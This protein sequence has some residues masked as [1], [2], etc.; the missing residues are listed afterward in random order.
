MLKRKATIIVLALIAALVAP[1][2]IY[3]LTAAAQDAPA[4][5]AAER[6]VVRAGDVEIVVRAGFNR[7]DVNGNTGGWVPFRI[8]VSNQGEPISGRLIVRSESPANPNK[9][10]REFVKDVQLP[11]GSRQLHNISAFLNSGSGPEVKL[12]TNDNQEIAKLTL[13]I[14]RHMW[15]SD[16]LEIAVVDTD[17]TTLNNITSTEIAR[18]PLREPFKFG[19]FA[20][21]S[22]QAN[23]P[24]P[25]GPQGR[26]SRSS[27][28]PQNLT[29][30]PIVV[31]SEDLPRE[32]VSYDPVDVVVIGDAPLSQLTEDQARALRL[33]VASGGMLVVTGA[34]DIAGLRA[35]GLDAMLPVEVQ[36]ATT[37]SSLGA[38]SA[39]YGGFESSDPP[40]AM[41]ATAR[42]G[43]VPLVGTSD[44]PIVAERNYGSGLVRFLAINPKINPY[45]GWAA[46]KY[47][48][49]DMLLPAAEAKPRQVNWITVGRRNN[50][51]SSSLG[52]RNFLF[53]LAEIEPPSMKYFLFFL[54]LYLLVVGPINYA[55]LRWKRKL[56]LAWLT[57]PAVVVVFT[58][59]SIAIAQVTRGGGS[60]AAD[61]SLVELHQQEGIRRHTGALLIMPSSK[62][63]EEISFDGADT[64]VNDLADN[65]SVTASSAD[66][67]ES[68]RDPKQFTLSVP[69]TTWTADIFKVRS[70]GEGAAPLVAVDG[71]GSGSTVTIKNVGDAPITRAVFMSTAGVSAQFDIA[72]GEQQQITLASPQA[73][74]FTSWYQSQFDSASHESQ[75]FSELAGVLDR[76]IGGGRVFRQGFFDTLTMQAALPQL[77]RPII[78]GFVDRS[79]ISMSFQDSIRRRGKT[80]YVVHL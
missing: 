3:S 51:M 63:T 56:D 45:R 64:F 26:R 53:E 49:T 22:Q 2:L 13:N 36:G 17:P 21:P 74:T 25:T 29:A 43:A 77:E 55:I 16:Q 69:L 57:I 12:V 44:S 59:V 70:I 67:I 6:G 11:T 80:F 28:T 23:N 76:E 61:V 32:F 38:L 52:M 71:S 14:D 40:L 42:A 9:Q 48:W 18:S 78:V 79:A 54:L 8:T 68:R 75:I 66:T 10:A 37:A 60:I 1:S 65:Y 15:T 31:A 47:L 19:P 24:Q 58:V 20:D 27:Q 73:N 50:R 4:E 72:P 5:P 7:L 33:W 41:S 46:A 34:A 35:A 39:V 62:G 30:H